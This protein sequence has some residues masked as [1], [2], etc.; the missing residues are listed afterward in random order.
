M[1]P[2]NLYSEFPSPMG[3][4]KKITFAQLQKRPSG[5]SIRLRGFRYGLFCGHPYGED[6]EYIQGGLWFSGARGLNGERVEQECGF[7]YTESNA[8]GHIFL[9]RLLLD[10]WPLALMESRSEG[11]MVRYGTVLEVKE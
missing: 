10:P 9:G 2:V 4:P 6:E 7:I 5:Y 1:K 8:K 3:E 11:S